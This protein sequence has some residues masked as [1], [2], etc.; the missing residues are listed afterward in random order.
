MVH[1]IRNGENRTIIECEVTPKDLSASV[2]ILYYTEHYRSLYGKDVAEA[3]YFMDSMSELSGIRSWWW[4]G[5][6]DSGKWNSIDEFVKDK[7]YRF[8]VI[9][10]LNYSQD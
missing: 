2:D 10:E 8:A 7:F 5:E 9:F 6:E 1:F 3:V 4:E